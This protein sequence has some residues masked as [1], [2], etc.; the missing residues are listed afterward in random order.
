MF[1]DGHPFCVD[2]VCFGDRVYN[3]RR[4]KEK[5][6]NERY[7]NTCNSLIKTERT[8][9]KKQLNEE[10]NICQHIVI[11]NVF[12]QLRYIYYAYV[13]DYVRLPSKP[14]D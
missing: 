4:R 3:K 13:F 7:K 14:Q 6:F 2:K 12:S 5:V 8:N 1:T 9:D 11:E 10:Q